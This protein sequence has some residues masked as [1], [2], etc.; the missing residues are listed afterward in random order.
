[1]KN[2]IKILLFAVIIHACKDAE[3]QPKNHPF[4]ITDEV[5]NND[6]SGVTFS[7]Q[8]IPGKGEA[9][10]EYGFI[11]GINNEYVHRFPGSS[12]LPKQFSVRVGSDLKINTTFACKAY[13][14]TKTHTIYGNTVTFIP[15]G[16]GSPPEIYNIHPKSGFD[17]EIITLN[18]KFFSYDMAKNIVTMNDLR[19]SVV[20][21][22]A[23][24]LAFRIPLSNFT[25]EAFINISVNDRTAEAPSKLNVFGPEIESISSNNG[26]P[27]E[28]LT[29]SGKNF[30]KFGNV[31][32]SFNYLNDHQAVILE[33]TDNKLTVE[34]P[35]VTNQP[36][37]TYTILKL[38][39]GL[40]S[41]RYREQFLVKYR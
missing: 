36:S 22:T 37:D 17:N 24:S 34:I 13:S 23:D 11:W 12:K 8:M 32:V 30:S 27:G 15:V 21:S 14:A 2:T 3:I 19:A 20:W 25:G 26:F 9:I 6:A 41:A 28:K 5:S 4:M 31:I 33:S 35:S 39:C 29:I 40:K 10:D 38:Q 1:M 16:T 18:G 7:A